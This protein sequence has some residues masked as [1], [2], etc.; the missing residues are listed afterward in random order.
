[1][2]KKSIFR[3]AKTGKIVTKKYAESHPATT[4][5]ETVVTPKK[6]KN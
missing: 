1:M 6:P 4:V 5:K 2:A 3:S